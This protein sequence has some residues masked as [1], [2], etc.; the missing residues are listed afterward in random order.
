MSSKRSGSGHDRVYEPTIWYYNLLLF[1][2]DQ[3]T[4]SASLWNISESF[5]EVTNLDQNYKNDVP[6][7]E[8]S[9]TNLEKIDDQP[10]TSKFFPV[11][12]PQ[13]V[14]TNKKNALWMNL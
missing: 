12:Q 4:L 8:D 13:K 1:T 10:A 14:N 7:L 11:S 3:E 5:P 9:T 6:E 2:I